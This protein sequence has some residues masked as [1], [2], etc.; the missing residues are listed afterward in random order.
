[1]FKCF[2]Y[3]HTTTSVTPAAAAAESIHIFLNAILSSTLIYE[4]WFLDSYI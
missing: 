2:V 3:K 4:M 1:M